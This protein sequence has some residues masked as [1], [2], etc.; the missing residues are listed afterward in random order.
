MTNSFSEL[1]AERQSCRAFLER[2]VDR[3]TIERILALAQHTASWCNVQPWQLVVTSGAATDRFRESMLR[4]AASSPAPNPDF[5][6]PREYQGIYKARRRTCGFQLYDSVG[7]AHGDRQA[8]ARQALENYRL[9]G[10]PHVAIVT[11]PEALGV[12]GALD[13]GA[14]VSNFML[15]ANSLGVATIAQASLAAWPDVVRAYFG[16]PEERRIVCGIS[17]GYE[18]HQHPAN[19]YRTDRA[20]LDDVV[21]WAQ[22]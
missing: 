17:F 3:P 13:C 20:A 19:Q 11:T 7:I 16:L 21:T 4:V 9:F 5:P 22:A 1:L 12:Y 15:A 10:A 18:D 6:Y 2:T 8:S 14:Y